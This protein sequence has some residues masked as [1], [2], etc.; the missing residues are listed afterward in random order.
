MKLN[1]KKLN[2]IL[3]QIKA[4]LN[5]AVMMDNSE[6]PGLVDFLFQPKSD[7]IKYGYLNRLT[8][9]MGGED[10]LFAETIVE[11]L[12]KPLVV[13][14]I[15]LKNAL[16]GNENEP[17]L[18]DGMVNGINIQVNKDDLKLSGM[19]NIIIENWKH[20][21]K[22]DFSGSIKFVMPRIDY[23]LMADT[24]DRFVSHD[25]TRIFMCG[26][27]I[28]FNKGEDF[29]NF[30]ATDGRRLA[31]CKFPCEHPKTDDDEDR[32]GDFIFNT[33]HFFIPESAYSRT[34]WAVA[35]NEYVAFIRIQTE[36]YSIE[37]W[38]KSIEGRFPNY[39]RVIPDKEQNK[40]W[41]SLNARSA[42]N[43]FDSIKG[44]INNDNYSSV[45]NQVFFDAEDPK[46][47]KLAIPDA[48]VDIDGE[49]SRSMCIRVNWNYMNP[50]FF[51]TPFTKFFLRN[52]NAALLTEETRAVRGT[53]MTVTK[54]VM[55]L[56]HEDYSD[57]WGIVKLNQQGK[58][59]NDDISKESDSEESD[60]D[61]SEDSGTIEYG[62]SL[63]SDA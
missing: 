26:Y 16:K 1:K 61:S 4:H 56:E 63:N 17:E 12:G 53:T 23:E 10:D 57:E 54:V 20:I 29:I 59:A 27:N 32:G 31:I 58:P 42:R 39:I 8:C 50:A 38:A 45:K 55:P 47:I 62:D 41:I 13:N 37:C 33:S 51:D 30:V 11:T 60:D 3:S 5:V 22:L 2:N 25:P 7:E 28:D 40:E 43:A 6:Y 52:V 46:R 21:K 24:M 44:L 15:R 19:G 14:I 48:Q 9:S 34:Q 18:K 36:D 49:A 35:V